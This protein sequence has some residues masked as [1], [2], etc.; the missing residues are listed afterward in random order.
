MSDGWAMS[1]HTATLHLTRTHTPFL[2]SHPTQLSSLSPTHPPTLPPSL[3]FPLSPPET[4]TG[5]GIT[6]AY[7]R[8]KYMIEEILKDFK[9]STDLDTKA[10]DAEVRA[11]VH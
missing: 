4:P 9:R 2:P 5:A 11:G 10:C 1:S 3:S 7:G 8:T 6:N